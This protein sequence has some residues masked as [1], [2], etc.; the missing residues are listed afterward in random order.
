MSPRRNERNE[1][2]YYPEIQAFIEAQLKSNFRASNNRELEVFWGIG[3]LRTNLQRIL[4]ENPAKC[5]CAAAFVQRTPP[6]NLDIFALITDSRKFEILILEVKLMNAAGL[7]EWSQLVGYCLVSRAKYGLLINIDKG[8]SPRLSQLLSTEEHLSHIQTIV[9]EQHYEHNLG[10]ME[11]DS[12]T[13]SFEYSNL[14]LIKSL[15][16]LSNRL[17]AE[18]AD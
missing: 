8:A 4:R 2:S 1:V 9:N 15:S 14:G 17:S 13:R 18:F 5:A 12:L 7:K 6:L 11:W 16:D 3:E 10:F